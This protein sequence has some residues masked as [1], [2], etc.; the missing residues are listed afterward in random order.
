MAL[1]PRERPVFGSISLH[2]FLR[3]LQL[4][5]ALIGAISIGAGFVFGGFYAF[6]AITTILGSLVDIIIFFAAP[7]KAQYDSIPARI[8]A[9]S[10]ATYDAVWSF[11][12][13]ITACLMATDS[14]RCS[15]WGWSYCPAWGAAAAFGK[16]FRASV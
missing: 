5:F 12:W 13:L 11:F 10:E 8:N 1:N 4:I 6:V 3:I 2:L 14:A 16:C 7:L 15:S 9:F